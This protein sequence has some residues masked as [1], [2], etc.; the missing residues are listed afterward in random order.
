MSPTP[1]VA[2]TPDR[3]QAWSPQ[4]E[5]FVA[6]L[7]DAEPSEAAEFARW[8][9]RQLP[10]RLL[11]VV[12]GL[13]LMAPGL[14]C[15]AVQAPWWVALGLEAAGVAANVWLR[16]ER[17]RNAAAIAGWAPDRQPGA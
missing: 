4:L 1:A 17:R 11:V 12:L 10:N 13:A 14:I 9:R 3:L 6:S 15:F 7:T 2:R 8:R 5:A 16:R